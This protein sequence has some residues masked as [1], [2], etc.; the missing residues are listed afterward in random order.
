[1]A[2]L[3][4]VEQKDNKLI[5]TKEIIETLSERELNQKIENLKS[6]IQ[7]SKKMIEKQEKDLNFYQKVKEKL[8]EVK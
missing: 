2:E 8:M 7:G 1:M 6:N 4:K 3:K 5:L